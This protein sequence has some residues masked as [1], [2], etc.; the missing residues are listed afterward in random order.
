M[1]GAARGATR[2]MRDIV[3]ISCRRR[4]SGKWARRSRRDRLS[5]PDRV[6]FHTRSSRFFTTK[7]SVIKSTVFIGGAFA[8]SKNSDELEAVR[9]SHEF[10]ASRW[11]T[12]ATSNHTVNNGVSGACTSEAS[13][14]AC[15]HRAR[16]ILRAAGS[17]RSSTRA[18]PR[19]SA[20][21]CVDA[22]DT[23]AMGV[24]R[25]APPSSREATRSFPSL[26]LPKTQVFAIN[27]PVLA[28]VRRGSSSRASR[29]P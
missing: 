3:D 28:K 6:T 11:L 18:R 10:T 9:A 2:A 4:R 8:N 29:P 25:C 22:I 12:R 16:L 23:H 21:D 27:A 14:A 5:H 1:A 24:V 19:V 26:P 15:A 17:E 13:C 20:R 7:R